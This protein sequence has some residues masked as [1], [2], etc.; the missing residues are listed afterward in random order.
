MYGNEG[1]KRAIIIF[2]NHG[3]QM[4]FFNQFEIIIIILAICS[5]RLI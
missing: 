5:F 1:V 3:E 2:I 4:C